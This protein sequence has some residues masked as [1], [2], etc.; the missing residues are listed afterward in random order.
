MFG[1]D[2]LYRQ[3]SDAMARAFAELEQ[4]YS[5]ERKTQDELLQA[6]HYRLLND[7]S[8]DIAANRFAAP[9]VF[10][11]L[12]P[13]DHLEIRVEGKCGGIM[14]WKPLEFQHGPR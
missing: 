1:P 4:T 12:A 3:K 14:C 10:R 9:C 2:G 13:E 11:R 7:C 6:A 5:R 8:E